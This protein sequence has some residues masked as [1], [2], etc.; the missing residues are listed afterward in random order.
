MDSRS[1]K[2]SGR[3]DDKLWLLPKSVVHYLHKIVTDEEKTSRT[4]VDGIASKGGIDD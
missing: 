3:L 4:I 2:I 1:N